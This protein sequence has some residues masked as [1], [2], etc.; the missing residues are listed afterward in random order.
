MTGRRTSLIWLGLLCAVIGVFAAVWLVPHLHRITDQA[1]ALKQLDGEGQR[2]ASQVEDLTRELNHLLAGP[3][4]EQ[5]T[6]EEKAA[7]AARAQA[8]AEATK[9]LQDVRTLADS[10]ER[11]TAAT[12]TIQQFE[13][14]VDQLEQTVN[15]LTRQNQAATESAADLKERLTHANRVIQAMQ[16]EL[17]DNSSRLTDL[18]VRYQKLRDEKQKVETKISYSLKLVREL[19]VLQLRRENLLRTIIQRYQEIADQYRTVAV[20]VSDPE[21]EGPT[22]GV[23]VSRLQNAISLASDDLRQLHALNARAFFIEKE[24]NK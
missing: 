13:D 10:Q 6:K 4:E 8:R 21:Q 19:Q 20:R 3:G 24:L 9:R 2:L 22:A 7:A 12:K 17:K 14:R 5:L 23:D 18:Q 16:I 15:K 11:L 1:E